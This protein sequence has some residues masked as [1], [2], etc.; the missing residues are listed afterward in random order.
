MFESIRSTNSK[1]NNLEDCKSSVRVSLPLEEKEDQPDMQVLLNSF[2]EEVMRAALEPEDI[3]QGKHAIP[4]PQFIEAIQHAISYSFSRE[5]AD[6]LRGLAE[7]G[8]LERLHFWELGIWQKRNTEKRGKKDS[9][10]LNSVS[11]KYFTNAQEG[12]GHGSMVS[13]GLAKSRCTKSKKKTTCEKITQKFL[14]SG[15]TS[16]LTLDHKLESLRTDMQMNALEKKWEFIVMAGEMNKW[17]AEAKGPKPEFKVINEE[18]NFLIVRREGD[19]EEVV[20]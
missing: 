7:D 8:A 5:E 17:I 6:C 20:P 9:R 3:W 11:Q 2:R 10:L 1:D 15:F 12:E 16:E 14:K 18:G 4:I 19:C 13:D